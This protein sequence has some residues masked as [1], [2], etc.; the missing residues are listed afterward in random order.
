VTLEELISEWRERTGDEATP[1]RVSDERLTRWLNE[2][3]RE[4][5]RRAKLL[6]DSTTAACSRIA[7]V[8]GT[9]TYAL[10]EKVLFVRKAWLPDARFLSRADRRD[11]DKGGPEW[12]TDSGEVVAFVP[13]MGTGQLRLFRNPDAAEVAANPYLWMTVVRLPLT[14]MDGADT[15]PEI[16]ER[17]H[18]G[19]LDW[20]EAKFYG[21][22]DEDVRNPDKERQ[23]L[24]RFAIEFGPPATAIEERWAEENYGF[25]EDDGNVYGG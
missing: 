6:V 21:L 19:L 4:A 25:I 16:H 2:A 22:R 9:S 17:L 11:L 20:A 5:C 1:P 10:H 12:M 13:N 24:D 15:E 7:L 3:E 14:D 23:A 18:A 8:A